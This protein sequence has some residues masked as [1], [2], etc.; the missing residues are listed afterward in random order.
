MTKQILKPFEFQFAGQRFIGKIAASKLPLLIKALDASPVAETKVNAGRQLTPLGYSAD[1]REWARAMGREVGTRG[2]MG[3][4]V[5]EAYEA[6]QK[7]A[8]KAL[9]LDGS[10][11]TV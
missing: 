1:V 9:N 6:A 8:K 11:V 7:V 2:R 3:Q 4:E 5:Y 10:E